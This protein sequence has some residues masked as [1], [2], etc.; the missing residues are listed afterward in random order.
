MIEIRLIIIGV[1]ILV[2]FFVCWDYFDKEW[3]KLERKKVIF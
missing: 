1:C 2:G 3:K